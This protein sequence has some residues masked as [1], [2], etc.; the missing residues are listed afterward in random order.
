MATK[1]NARDGEE[2]EAVAPSIDL[3]PEP[4]TSI[5]PAASGAPAPC[6]PIVGIGA[7]AGGLET[8]VEL[9][10]QLPQDSGMAFVLIQH[11][12]ATQP[13]YLSEA[14]GRATH[15]PVAEVHDGMAVEPDH[16]YVIPANADVGVLR[17]KLVLVP[18]PTTGPHLPIDFFFKSLATD[19]ENRAIGVVLSGTGADGAEG[20]QAIRADEGVT[21]AQDPQSA[22]FSGMPEAAIKTGAVDFVLGI[23]ELA[24]ELLRVGRHPFVRGSEP[25]VPTGPGEEVALN[26]VL[27]LLRSAVGVDF[28]EYKLMSV[29]R[30]LARRM[31][32]HRL[33]TLQEYVLLL[34]DEP[35]EAR[36]LLEDL[37]IH[38]T[39]F[40]RDGEAFEALKETVFPEILKQKRAGG[41][42]RIWSAGCSTGEEAY[43]IVIALLELLEQ[44]GASGVPVQLFGTDISDKAVAIAR[45]G[46]Y[47]ESAMRSIGPARLARFFSKVEGGGYR[48]N[49]A[50]RERCAFAKHDVS[51]DPPFSKL[52]L[53]SCRNLMIYLGPP[54][55]KRVLSTFQFAL[56][57][58]G[59]LLLGRAESVAENNNLFLPL[60]KENKIFARTAAKSALPLPR[61]RQHPLA[62]PVMSQGLRVLT[63]LDVVKRS[64]ALLLDEYAPAGVIVNERMEI[65]HFRG[66]TSPYLEPAPGPPQHD[67]FKMARNGLIADLRIA[68]SQS[69]REMD[70][71]RRPSTCVDDRDVS[72]HCDIVVIPLSAPSES[73]DPLFIVLFE[74]TKDAEPLGLKSDQDAS[75]AKHDLRADARIAQLEQTLNATKEHLQA[76]IEDHRSANEDLVA[77]NEEFLSG[78]EELQSLNEELET[79]KEELQSTNEELSTLNDELQ[80]RNTELDSVNSDLVNILGS[81]EVAIVIVDASRRIR[82]FTPKARP[83][84]S[85][86]PSDVG[87]PIDDIRST[88]LIED[89]DEK[90]A[91]VIETVTVRE[92]EAQSR[93]GRW[94][95]LQIRPYMTVDKRIDGAVLSIVD[96]DALKRALSAAMWVRDYA[97]ATVEAVQTP[98]MLLDAKLRVL[99]VNEAFRETYGVSRSETEGSGVYDIMKSAWDFPE[100]RSAL[101]RVAQSG[102]PFQ[103]LEAE[104]EIPGHGKRWASLAGR[105]VITPNDERLVLLAVEDITERLHGE[106]ER[107][108]LLAESEAAKASAEE[109]NRAKDLFL[110]ALSHE[111]RTPLSTLLLQAQ[112][113]RRG[114]MDEARLRKAS[115]TIERATMAQAQLIDDLL[116]VSRIVTGKL[117]MR[118]RAL[119]LAS[120]V[121]GAVDTFSANAEKKGVTIELKLDD[122]LPPVSGDFA[123]LQQATLNLLTNA[124]K[125]TPAGGTVT[126]TVD[127]FHGQG[128][129]RVQDT[130]IGIDS[131]FLPEIFNRFSQE[132]RGQSRS[133]GGLGLGLAIA[134]SLVEAHGG[135]IEADSLG[136]GKGS[137]FTILLPLMPPSDR[138]EQLTDR[139]PPGDPVASIKNVRVLV[140]EDDQGTREALTEMLG[141][142]GADVR[143]ADCAEA[144]MLALEDQV[145]ELLVCDIAMPHE[146]GYSL[147]GRIRALGPSR[148][149]NVPALALTAHAGEEDRRRAL[150]AGFQIHMAK[151]VDGDH[152]I[153]ALSRLLETSREQPTPPRAQQ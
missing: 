62:I 11:L 17:G 95:R 36:A 2:L 111:L 147:L 27:V 54:L 23:P 75:V 98:L 127:S 21:F 39:S 84:L 31:A 3:A 131:Q 35:S 135:T 6:F 148:G 55:Q 76:I 128:R 105:S 119:H 104:R 40:F 137:T 142:S 44:Q 97:R 67:L 49:A 82:R 138:T 146:D 86:L 139:P 107:S 88:L 29:R 52:D 144:A 110:A 5:E 106:A 152:L 47:P 100:L 30:R 20:L 33:S 28:S 99:S 117:S 124:L 87:R 34:R 68:I 45:I 25:A 140:V 26:Q 115:E 92:E 24:Q 9:L 121:R 14:L 41:T 109:A 93:D 58:P 71:V 129:I 57:E 145:P 96:I 70:T 130:G 48:I 114:V 74:E 18:R 83:I 60:D 136:K 149:G 103:Q 112:L 153:G 80:T 63:P 38:V 120:F 13:S 56:N 151:P 46:F 59:F 123:R 141:L 102:D 73:R 50:V 79:A 66:R 12:D 7:S 113:L 53:V 125:F 43:S 85:L 77:T 10:Q 118:L 19:R 64:E 51:S 122:S 61:P 134:R 150:A 94:Y 4:T 81:V 22:K 116:D 72:H 143:S 132:D 32:V 69:Q 89:L 1:K 126:V 16:V 108:R 37:L 91:D 90:I 8:F 101:L 78:N 42:I 15:F 65:L 133:H